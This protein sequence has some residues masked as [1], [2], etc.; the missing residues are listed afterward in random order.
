MKRVSRVI[1]YLLLY[2]KTEGNDKETFIMDLLEK[3]TF[4]TLVD[5]GQTLTVEHLPQEIDTIEAYK[6]FRDNISSYLNYEDRL[7]LADLYDTFEM[8]KAQKLVKDYEKA[9]EEFSEPI[10]KK[11]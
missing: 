8:I 9:P 7:A 6:Q 4:E 1:L 10:P 3:E 2:A 5:P 11:S